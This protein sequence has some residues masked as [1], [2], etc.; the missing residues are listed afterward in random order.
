[1]LGDHLAT[2]VAHAARS[3]VRERAASG[4]AVSAVLVALLAA[5]EVDGALVCVTSVEDGR[6]RARYRIA[7]TTA[8]VLAAQG[9]T[10]VL[11]DFL[12]EAMPQIEAFEGRL[13]VVALP[14]EI[15]A[16]AARPELAGKV[17][18]RIALFCGHATEPRLVDALVERLARAA[19]ADPAL[20]AATAAPRLTAFRF[21]SGHWRGRLS[22]QFAAATADAPGD[23]SAAPATVTVER[24]FSTYSLYQNLYYCAARKC[25]SCGDHFGYDADMSA[26]DLWSS[27]YKDDPVKHTALLVKTAA[28]ARA[29]D[30]AQEA[31]TLEATE[32]SSAEILDGQRRT[33]PFHYNVSA[34]AKAGRRLGITVPDRG[35]ATGEPVRVRWHEYLAARM[36]L[37]G[38]IRT[39]T[40]EAAAAVLDEPRMWHT[41]RLYVLKGLE[42]LS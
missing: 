8:E 31:G 2:Y 9:S 22:A 11:G 4:G 28:G 10:Y 6:V 27:R 17:A 1:M 39:K 37:R 18:L 12:R 7:R 5:G 26:G 30:V 19:A 33:A 35:G 20:A 36:V 41:V 16:L 25:L 15:T 13:A 3:E 14:C 40:D 24:P 38:Y 34:R 23:A 29:L 21:R 32:V 42:S